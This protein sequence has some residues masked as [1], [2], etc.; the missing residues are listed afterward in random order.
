MRLAR[1]GRNIDFVPLY[2]LGLLLI[3]GIMFVMVM[4]VH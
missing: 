4:V 1:P 3:L 2:V